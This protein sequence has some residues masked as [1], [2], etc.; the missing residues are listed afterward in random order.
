[1]NTVWFVCHPYGPPPRKDFMSNVCLWNTQAPHHRKILVSSQADIISGGK[2]FT[3]QSIRFYGEWECCSEVP[4]NT[5]S[6]VPISKRVHSPLHTRLD[7]YATGLNT[8]PYVFGKEFYYTCC[9]LTPAK[10][11]QIGQG[12][13][14][15]FGSFIL[16]QSK[17]IDKMV[18]DT[19]LVVKEKMTIGSGNTGRFSKCFRDV[20]LSKILRNGTCNI[21][22]GEMYNC[23]LDY[24]ANGLFSFVPCVEANNNM[25][26][27]EIDPN[28]TI[29]GKSINFPIGINGGH[30]QLSNQL[31]IKSFF[32]QMVGKVTGQGYHLGVYMPEPSLLNG[33]SPLAT[34]I[35]GAFKQCQKNKAAT[36]PSNQSCSA[37]KAD[38]DCANL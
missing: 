17:M 21:V 13:I 38:A 14:V 33:G 15:I 12:D 22:V 19:V 7:V 24:L 4:L 2:F 27:V 35:S 10:F 5:K 9:K 31:E 25:K 26:R 20:T 6:T 1:M 23:S 16:T 28:F 8:D 36:A 11:A 32:D 29:G 3:Q 18:V 37:K 34:T 30:L